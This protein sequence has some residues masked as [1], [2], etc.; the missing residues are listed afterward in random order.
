MRIKEKKLISFIKFNYGNGEQFAKFCSLRSSSQQFQILNTFK[1]P[2]DS[3]KPRNSQKKK[4]KLFT[5]CWRNDFK[6][7]FPTIFRWQNG[8]I[9]PAQI[10]AMPYETDITYFLNNNIIF[11]YFIPFPEMYWPDCRAPHAV[12]RVVL[13]VYLYVCR[14]MPCHAI[15]WIKLEQYP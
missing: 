10:Q 2:N 14:A 6:E 13:V 4:R 3:S 11:P 15:Q 7:N 5:N 12:V 8:R 9:A 1:H